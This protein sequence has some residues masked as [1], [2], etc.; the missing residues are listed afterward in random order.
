MPLTVLNVAYPFAPVRPNTAGGAEQVVGMLDRALT[1][2]GHRS[3]VIACEGSEVEGT[4]IATT[5][6]GGTIDDGTRRRAAAEY[7][8][9][10]AGAAE[11]RHI[12]LIHLHGIDFL[13]YLPGPGVPVVVTLH[14][15]PA[16]YDPRVF[17]IGRPDTWLHCVSESQQAA[18]PPCSALLPPIA[19][20][21]SETLYA[22]A[23]RK[24]G[25]AAALGRIC[26]EK[27]YHIAFDAAER[28]GAA[29]L[30]AGTVYPYPDHERYYEEQIVP[31]CGRLRRFI[32]PAGSRKKRRLLSAAS[33]LLVPSLAPET[34]SLVAMESL[35]CGTPV[36][37]FPAGAL[38]G[39]VE[40]GRTGFLVENEID[41]AEAIW[42]CG[43]LDPADCREAARRRFSERTTIARYLKMYESL[44]GR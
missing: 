29:L 32:G 10:I 4:L 41:M 1:Q 34:S 19:N 39:I 30:L 13:E 6:P 43:K 9:A 35:M 15:P 11:S 2:A 33:C 23:I 17:S 21:V 38:A 3:V 37:A 16:W 36:V 12:D 14:L 26:P 31:R 27:G 42:K 8:R 44:A 40:P 5:P 18:C 22:P 24:R 7:G 20:G 28:A 25:F